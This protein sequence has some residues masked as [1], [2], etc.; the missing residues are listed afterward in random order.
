MA[1]DR[2]DVMNENTWG[3]AALSNSRG[4]AG[5]FFSVAAVI[6]VLTSFVQPVRAQS[7][8]T[9]D[10]RVALV[11]GVSKYQF[12]PSLQNPANDARRI[13]EA[14]R[15]LNFQVEESYD[16]DYRT[17][18]QT[19]RAF[20]IR[21][22]S[23]DAALIFYAGHGVQ[24]DHEN[25]LLPA[26]AKLEREHDLVYEALS[27]DLFLGEVSQAKRVGILL[28]DACRNN[29]F[30]D[31][32]SR[33]FDVVGRASAAQKGLARIDRVPRNT[34][35]VM[36]TRSDEIAE[37]GGG[38]NSPFAQALLAHFQIPGLELSLFFRSVRDTVLKATSDRQEP[39][40]FSSLGA[41]PFYF[42][43]RPPNRPPVIGSIAKLEISDAAGF[44]P[45]GLPRPTDPD[46][47]PLTVRIV[48]LPRAGEVRID[49]KQVA[50]NDV[51]TLEKFMTAAYKPDNTMHGAVGSFDFLVDDG[52]G[53][54]VVGSLPITVTSSNH[55]P[56]VE[57][58][59][60]AQI[61]AGSLGIV[62]PTDPDNDPLTVTITAL[63]N[64]GVIRN[65]PVVVKKGDRLR[66]QDMP[67]LIY[68]PD[69]G[70]VGDAGSLRY[71]VEDGHGGKAE[72][73]V[74]INV[75]PLDDTTRLVSDSELW[76]RLRSQGDLAAVQSFLRLFPDSQYASEARQRERELSSSAPAAAN[77]AGSGSAP[78]SIALNQ[79]SSPRSPAPAPAPT[80]PSAPPAATT[81]P[82]V[83]SV[84]APP[85]APLRG[86]Q[87]HIAAAGS[88]LATTTAPTDKATFKECA[89]C[90]TMVQIAAG[91]FSMGQSGDST[92]MP[93]HRVAI[94]RFALGERPVTVAEW[95]ACV[96]D[97]GCPSVRV[98][99]ADDRTSMHNL[100]WDD[101]QQ[102][103]AWL[104]K[105]TGH[106]YRLPT[107]AEW[108]Y[109]ARANTAT[110]YWWGDQVGIGLANCSDCGGEQN[111]TRP[112]P[113][114]G[115]KPNAFGV[116]G[117]LG[118]VSQWM[119]DCWF[120]NYDGAPADGSL[121]DR[122]NCDRHVLR[123][124]SFRN[125]RNNITASVR[126]YYD[127]SVRYPGNG[128]RVAA[129]LL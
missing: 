36:A 42:Y 87:P 50:A 45:L 55:P 76:Q 111:K 73:H 65:G 71:L 100:S 126:N 29:P 47:D 16:A 81:L 88:A 83:K 110:R 99:E 13:A 38:D 106:S 37:D 117:A 102:Y 10:K 22:Q 77:P 128:F 32:M 127:T 14:L 64:R 46:N 5:W 34:I 61:F 94:R 40:V 78:A 66:A 25:Y 15:R 27:L 82:P 97:N 18:T 28:L 105:K 26:D 6:L 11:I 74:Q 68:F 96:A 62:A 115:Y 58:D 20:G 79:P 72:G 56:V 118:G 95:K 112:L 69:S 90:P 80:P 70:T 48:G 114:D 49:G 8:V 52:R 23:A 89:N 57:A 43:P 54:N 59:R 30:I 91:S 129:D 124:G 85:D 19:L 41:E 75:P 125:D 109:A 60:V 122:K 98:T 101:A 120:P 63:P 53:G 121:R 21:A 113:V 116:L 44:T 51:M 7:V 12:A 93:V 4:I 119:A 33:G 3:N 31:R 24:V 103:V 17:L 35:V 39:Y 92:A 1:V 107:E 108:E 84:P 2:G 67:A 86:E 123:G 104:S 9:S